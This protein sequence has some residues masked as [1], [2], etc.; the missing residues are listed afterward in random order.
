VGELLDPV[1]A[2][3]DE[4]V[5]GGEQ[6][7]LL[8][9]P[10]EPEPGAAGGRPLESGAEAGE[11]VG[12]DVPGG[13]GSRDCHGDSALWRGVTARWEGLVKRASLRP[14]SLYCEKA[15]A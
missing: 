3:G 11:G 13:A 6:G 8:G 15:A 7:Q 1:G 12:V 10:A 4:P 14:P 2:E 5:E 9:G